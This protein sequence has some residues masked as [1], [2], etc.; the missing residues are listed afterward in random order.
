M[1]FKRS[2]ERK[3]KCA[4]CDSK[5]DKN[6]SFCPHCGAI[7]LDENEAEDY[8]L[9]GKNDINIQQNDQ[10]SFGITDKLL[11]SLMNTLVKTLDKQ[12]KEL[13]KQEKFEVRSL[14]N[15]IKMNLKN[16]KNLR[17]DPCQMV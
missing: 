5:I 7:L 11:G 8:G 9:L 6:F 4:G 2:K 3:I 16:R 12:F 10:E 1:F 15:G 13:E 17:S 14:P